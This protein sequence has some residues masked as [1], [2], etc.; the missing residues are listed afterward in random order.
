[1][2]AVTCAPENAAQLLADAETEA[3]KLITDATTQAAKLIA[4]AKTEATK[5]IADAETEVAAR[6]EA[7]KTL[8]DA[9][10]EAAKMAV[11]A[12]KTL[13]TIAVAA[14]GVCLGYYQFMRGQQALS[15][16]VVSLVVVALGLFM[17]SMI[18]GMSVISRVY[19]RGEGRSKNQEWNN[20][21]W[22]TEHVSGPINIQA[23]SGLVGLILFGFAVYSGAANSQSRQWTI[24]SPWPQPAA[25][26]SGKV[27][28]IYGSWND[29]FVRDEKSNWIKLDN[30]PAGERRVLELR[31]Q[32]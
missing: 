8:V 5:L 7:A 11:D 18:S 28:T 10:K 29:L 16:P 15:S 3:C 2:S 27:I 24:D 26:L 6:K 19:K 20:Q 1:M 32:Q 14:S 4:D 9:Q 21:L 25:I 17:L 22:S 13:I 23:W 30:V 12:A 31:Q